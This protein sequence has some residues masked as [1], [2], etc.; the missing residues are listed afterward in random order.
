M[1]FLF[2][3]CN[4]NKKLYRQD[5]SFI[6]RCE[7]LAYQ[8]EL[9]GYRCESVHIEELNPFLSYDV[10]FFHRP[11]YSLKLHL[12]V[13]ILKHKGA[14]C[15]VDAD[16][17]VF[18]T[19]YSAY[20]PAYINGAWNLQKV[21]N[22]F[23]KTYKAFRLFKNFTLSTEPLQRHIIELFPKANTFV[24]PNSVHYS[25]L[26]KEFTAQRNSDMKII[27]YLPG[28]KSHDRDFAIVQNALECFLVK[29]KDVRIHITG[30][31]DFVL[32]VPKDKVSYKFKVP[33]KLHYK[34]YENVW[35]NI[36]PLEQ[37][38]FTESKSALKVIE[39][40]FFKIPTLCSSNSDNLRFSKAGAI[41]VENPNKWFDALESMYDSQEYKRV[42]EMIEHNYADVVSTQKPLLEL[43][44]FIK[45]E[46]R[47]FLRKKLLQGFW[48]AYEA[49][50][51][52]KQ[53]QYTLFTLQLYADAYKTSKK[54]KDYLAYLLFRRDLGYKITQKKAHKLKDIMQQLTLGEQKKA[55]KLLQE[56]F[57][58]EISPWHVAFET[59]LKAHQKDGICL[60]GN[61]ANMLNMKLGKKIDENGVVIRFNRC[62]SKPKH[63]LQRG[64]KIDVWVR[65]P[66]VHENIE[67]SVDW[68]IVSGA[69]RFFEITPKSEKEIDVPLGVWRDLVAL[70]HAPPSA[71]LLMIYWVYKIFGSFEGVCVA[72]FDSNT[73]TI[74][75]Y[76]NPSHKPSKRHNWIA[77][78]TLLN[79][80]KK[81]G[82]EFLN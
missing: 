70:L 53:G 21:Q 50:K 18:D 25:W 59:Y 9:L 8:L 72:G 35:L 15:I 41:V 61:S 60:V 7:N 38:P 27:S 48:Y 26:S 11:I 5:A 44:T 6:Y 55:D 46:Y 33:F 2:V 30:P 40:G 29:H 47:K 39:A 49:K 64:E 37:N 76:S 3:A 22:R 62:F 45:K 54:A 17:L 1:K 82:L 79:S 57:S 4:K 31:L 10:I 56:T 14:L 71:G 34:N 63:I 73:Q 51:R 19:R 74:Y 52:R 58:N 80:F 12:S 78:H 77:E 32:N 23:K 67:E 81:Q 43:L 36:A 13:A 68:R 42:Q 24:L 20:S 69:Q 28:T 65:A 75:H 66:D 16:D